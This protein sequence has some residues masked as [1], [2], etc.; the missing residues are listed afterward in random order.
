MARKLRSTSDREVRLVL[1]AEHL[2]RGIDAP[3]MVVAARADRDVLGCSAH[4]LPVVRLRI[5][6]KDL[7]TGIDAHDSVV[8]MDGDLSCGAG[9]LREL[10]RSADLSAPELATSVD[11]D[12]RAILS[13]RNVHTV[14]GHT[15]PSSAIIMPKLVAI[16]HEPDVVAAH[17][18]DLLAISRH[19]LP[20]RSLPFEQ[21]AACIDTPQ[22]AIRTDR[23]AHGSTGELL[24]IV[25]VRL[26]T[27]D[28]LT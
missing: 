18:R 6:S 23:D 22:R 27:P 21:L 5:P 4:L 7:P 25:V 16:I 12:D 28:L 2:V 19:L 24:P 17:N 26:Q 10:S 1:V 11:D 8:V 14:A 15:T 9:H 13:S 3:D 20:G